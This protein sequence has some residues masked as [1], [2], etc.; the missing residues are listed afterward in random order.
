MPHECIEVVVSPQTSSVDF[1]VSEIEA[2]TKPQDFNFPQNL[3]PGCVS[4]ERDGV[5]KLQ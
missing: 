2:K 4:G 5:A 3:S 1:A